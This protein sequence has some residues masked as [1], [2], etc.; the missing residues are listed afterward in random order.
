MAHLRASTQEDHQRIQRHSATVPREYRYFCIGHGVYNVNDRRPDGTR[1]EG[2][3]ELPHC[4]GLEIL[5]APEATGKSNDL[6]KGQPTPQGAAMQKPSDMSE[7]PSQQPSSTS[8]PSRSSGGPPIPPVPQQ[9]PTPD[10][11]L[12]SSRKILRAM[13]RNARLIGQVAVKGAVKGAEWLSGNDS[14]GRPPR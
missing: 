7:H 4:D 10:Q 9:L 2:T 5:A 12:A 1:P 14:N 13:E 3:P 6:V 11:I 8:P